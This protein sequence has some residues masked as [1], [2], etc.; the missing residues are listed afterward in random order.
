MQNNKKLNT[1]IVA[2]LITLVTVVS[3]LGF[4]SPALS[5][6]Q[7]LVV[8]YIG[9]RLSLVVYDGSDGLIQPRKYS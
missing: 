5:I 4:N 2:L 7:I 3:L 1:L 9:F 8:A 6:F